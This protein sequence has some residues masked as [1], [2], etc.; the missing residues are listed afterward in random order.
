MA[1][2]NLPSKPATLQTEF[3]SIEFVSYVS[4]TTIK[5]AKEIPLKPI[6]IYKTT[7]PPSELNQLQNERGK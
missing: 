2:I 5:N 6:L 3:C 4:L 7:I 1:L